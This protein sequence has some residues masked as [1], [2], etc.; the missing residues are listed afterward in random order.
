M[1]MLDEEKVYPSIDVY[2]RHIIEAIKETNE[3]YTVFI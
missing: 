3:L 1:D 2:K